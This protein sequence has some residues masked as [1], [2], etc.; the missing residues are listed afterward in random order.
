MMPRVGA[1][2]VMSLVLPILKTMLLS[3]AKLLRF[4]HSGA[5]GA[6]NLLKTKRDAAPGRIPPSQCQRSVHRATYFF[7]PRMYMLPLAGRST[8]TPCRVYTA[9]SAAASPE[10]TSVMASG[11]SG[12]S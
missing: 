1:P 6:L 11:V 2:T 7:P 9:S 5:N 4:T 8:R 10:P 12:L 3:G